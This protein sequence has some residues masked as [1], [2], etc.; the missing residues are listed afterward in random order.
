MILS[1]NQFFLLLFA[2]SL[3]VCF[4]YRAVWFATARRATGV[5][6]F[7]GH[8]LELQGNISAH[9]VIR[10]KAGKDSAFFNAAMSEELKPGQL[11]PVLY[12]ESDPEEAQVDAFLGLWGQSMIFMI[13]PVLVLL[14]LYVTPD[15]WDPVIPQKCKVVL[16]GGKTVLRIV[17][18]DA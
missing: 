4:G 16:F 7:V 9:A 12:H 2:L 14:I 3:G 10:Y 15:R 11:V 13:F 5:M 8:T 17:A 18:Y 6:Y 1:R